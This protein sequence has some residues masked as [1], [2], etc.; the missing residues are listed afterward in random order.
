ME[1]AKVFLIGCIIRFDI[2]SSLT[3]NTVPA[4]SGR[5]QQL[6]HT[7]SYRL[8]L[9]AALQC[10]TWIFSTLLDIYSLREWRERKEAEGM[11]SLRE[12]ISKAFPI[13]KT[14]E[15]GICLNMEEINIFKQNLE[16]SSD[17]TNIGSQ[18]SDYNMLAATH[19]FAC[20]VSIFLE[21]VLSG[22][23]PKLP[24]IQHEV[25]RALESY[26]YIHD[27]DFMNVFHWPLCVAA[28]VAE[29]DHY[30][31]FRSLL[32]SPN[33]AWIGAFRESLE[34][35]EEHWRVSTNM[36]TTEA[37]VEPAWTRKFMAWDIL[38]A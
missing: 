1:S 5:Y 19:I 23:L 15:R 21:V 29:L 3:E 11:L 14:L 10:R 13:K 34:R 16:G 30:D 8:P 31:S 2:L 25:G 7:S 18:Q 22:A 9:Q 37:G 36:K 33:I 35:L 6:L 17:C 27:P 12:L 20:S 32:S 4:L 26:S 28:S 24:E 38:I